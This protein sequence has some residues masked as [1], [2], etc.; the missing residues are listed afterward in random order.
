LAAL[1]TD[2]SSAANSPSNDQAVFLSNT[3]TRAASGTKSS[4]NRCTDTTASTRNNCYFSCKRLISG[5]FAL[6]IIVD[7]GVTTFQR[8]ATPL[9]SFE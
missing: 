7:S 1:V 2:D 4:G 9:H 5:I 3:P 6:E 8:F